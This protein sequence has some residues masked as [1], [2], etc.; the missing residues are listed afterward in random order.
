MP[1]SD[2]RVIRDTERVFP[3]GME[4]GK[5]LGFC[6]ASAVRAASIKRRDSNQTAVGKILEP[7]RSG[8]VMAVVKR[9]CCHSPRCLKES[10][11]SWKKNQI[12]LFVFAERQDLAETLKKALPAARSCRSQS[13]RRSCQGLGPFCAPQEHK[14]WPQTHQQQA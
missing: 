12:R 13:Q 2:G 5:K 8:K 10:G 9:R 3:C 6:I 7:I 1:A 14:V 4:N 11:R